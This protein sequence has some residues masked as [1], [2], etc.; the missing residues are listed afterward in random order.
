VILLSA[1]VDGS[2]AAALP[3]RKTVTV[4]YFYVVRIFGA[5]DKTLFQSCYTLRLF[6]T[7]VIAVNARESSG[8]FATMQLSEANMFRCKQLRGKVSEC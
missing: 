6:C 7:A 3:A 8:I 4:V 5:T 2:L 1:E